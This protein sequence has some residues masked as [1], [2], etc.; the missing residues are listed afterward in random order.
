MG[1]VF[2]RYCG[3]ELH[4]TAP[5]CPHCGALQAIAKHSKNM[6]I[7]DGIKGWSWGAFLLNWIW[8]I[9]NRTWIG[10]FALIPL[11]G[12]IMAFTLGFKGREWAWRNKHW[13]SVEHFNQVQKKW[14]TWAIGLVSCG[15]LLNVIYA[16][17]FIPAYQDY[18]ARSKET[19]FSQYQ[20]EAPITAF[21]QTELQADDEEEVLSTASIRSDLISID[22]SREELPANVLYSLQRALADTEVIPTGSTNPNPATDTSWL[23][24][25]SQRLAKHIPDEAERFEFLTAIR[26][27]SERAGVDPQLMLGLIEVESGFRKYAVSSLGARGYTQIMPHWAEKIGTPG[28]NLF[29]LR[30]NLRYGAVLLR[31]YIDLDGGDYYGALGRYNNDPIGRPGYPFLVIG[32]WKSHWDYK[33]TTSTTDVKNAGK[34][35]NSVTGERREEVT[36]EQAERDR[37]KKAEGDECQISAECAGTLVCAR[38]TPTGMQCMSSDAALKRYSKFP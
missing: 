16:F 24:V 25:M 1:M 14:S 21:P 6:A 23:E 15:V 4:E 5:A 36:R 29:L 17:I 13:K 12:I 28:D 10:L 2:C 32:A 11:V 35:D 31:H 22:Q 20:P 18:V 30:T 38:V 19:E 34:A 3:K 33:P 9:G 7:P 8:A 27:E 26:L 37:L